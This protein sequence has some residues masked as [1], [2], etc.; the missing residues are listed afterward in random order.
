M[1]LADDRFELVVPPSLGLVCFR[2]K[3]TNQP[4]KFTRPLFKNETVQIAHT[5]RTSLINSALTCQFDS[6]KIEKTDEFLTP[7]KRRRVCSSHSTA[8]RVSL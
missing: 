3:V 6:S 7:C 1:L 4:F 5:S 8:L 2:L